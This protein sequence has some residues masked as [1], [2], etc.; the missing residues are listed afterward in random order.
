M[1]VDDLFGLIIEF[2]NKRKGKEIKY[3]VS[4]SSY[5]Q[6]S[7]LLRSIFNFYIDNIQPIRNPLNDKRMKGKEA[8]KR[9][10]QGREPFN[11]G[12]VEDILNKVHRDNE[13]DKADYLELIVLLFYNGFARADEIVALKEEMIDHRNMTVRLSGKTI[14]LSERC[15]ELLRKFNRLETIAGWRGDYMLASWHGSYFKFIIRPSQEK[16]LDSRPQTAMCDIIN[17]CIANNINDRYDVKINYR[18]LYMLGFFEFI[19]EK[20]G[21]EKASAMITSFRDSDDVS[22]LMS[23]ARMYGVQADNISHLKRHL[24]PFVIAE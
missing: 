5:D 19:S 10:A 8:T 7:S 15:Y 18:M 3:M 14:Q 12:V 17:R 2:R 6:M 21:I 24:R 4:H 20:H 9:L 1:E 23:L 16:L 13:K 22:E 11:W